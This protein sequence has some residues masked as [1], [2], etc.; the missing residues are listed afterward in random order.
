M[1]VWSALPSDRSR[2]S[3]L[4][5]GRVP[6]GMWSWSRSWDWSFLSRPG[7]ITVTAGVSRQPDRQGTERDALEAGDVPTMAALAAA[8]QPVPGL[9]TTRQKRLHG[10]AGLQLL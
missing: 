6:S 7:G 5:F 4:H 1:C 10:Q 8:G 2:R 9:G 3:R